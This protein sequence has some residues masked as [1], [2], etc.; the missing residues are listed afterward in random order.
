[1]TAPIVPH[2]WS[3][4][5]AD[6][7]WDDWTSAIEGDH[8]SY[9]LPSEWVDEELVICC[10]PLVALGLVHADMDAD[11]E[12]GDEIVSR[13][14]WA[15]TEARLRAWAAVGAPVIADK[16]RETAGDAGGEAVSRA[17]DISA[18]EAILKAA[19]T[20]RDTAV[21]ALQAA[22]YKLLNGPFVH[23]TRQAHYDASDALQTAYVGVEAAMRNLIDCYRAVEA[24][25][26]KP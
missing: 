15:S 19:E 22:H 4:A 21:D 13:Y 20:A 8:E 1:M 26:V 5:T 23:E 9:P 17:A 16:G 10:D 6:F 25:E 24:Q 11:D 2:G 18:A 3:R 7:V 12:T 14:A